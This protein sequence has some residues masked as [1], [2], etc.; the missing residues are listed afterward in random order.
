MD[1]IGKSIIMIPALAVTFVGAMLMF[2]LK[3]QI[4]VMIS[5]TILMSG[6]MVSTAVLNAKI[7]DYTPEKEAGLF[8]GVRMIFSVSV[9]MV[10]GPFIGEA[11]YK[12]TANPNNTYVD[13][14]NQTVIIP[15]EYIFLGAAIVLVVAIAPLVYIIVTERKLKIIEL[16]INND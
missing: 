15:N 10:T 7:R 5:G 12:A 13:G 9:P 6:Y 14:Y 8:Q 11:L 2:F 4:G 16:A 3:D 1:K